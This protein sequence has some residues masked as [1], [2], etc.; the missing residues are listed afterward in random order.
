M[1]CSPKT[2]WLLGRTKPSPAN[3]ADSPRLLHR[4]VVGM[5]PIFASDGKTL[6]VQG[7]CSHSTRNGSGRGR[8]I[9]VCDDVCS[10]TRATPGV[11][12]C[13]G[14]SKPKSNGR[15]VRANEHHHCRQRQGRA[16]GQGEHSSGWK[17]Q[18]RQRHQHHKT[19]QKEML[20][21]WETRLPQGGR[22][23]RVRSQCQQTLDG[24]EVCQEDRRG[25]HM[26]GT[27]DGK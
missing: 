23:L 14:D 11:T 19:N 22:L 26:T 25:D 21:L 2:K 9:N 6:A 10:P 16:T 8:R 20:T 17:C 7:C 4:E 5:P 18:L 27:G 3:L 15:N 12:Q 1:R 13:N 24:M